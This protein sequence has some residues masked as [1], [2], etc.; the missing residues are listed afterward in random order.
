[1]KKSILESLVKILD[2]EGMDYN[3]NPFP[4][5]EG[6]GLS[7]AKLKSNLILSIKP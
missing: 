5:S 3:C 4:L 2:E 1:M 6:N 7:A